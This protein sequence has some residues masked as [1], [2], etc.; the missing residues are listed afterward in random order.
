M[1]LALTS[2]QAPGR[3]VLGNCFTKLGQPG[4]GKTFELGIDMV[5]DETECLRDGADIS[6]P[7][8]KV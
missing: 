6:R 4:F 3:P 8:G 5:L 2:A 7:S 1:P